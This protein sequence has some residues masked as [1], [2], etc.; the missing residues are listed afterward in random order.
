[1]RRRIM[2][3]VTVCIS[4]MFTTPMPAVRLAAIAAKAAKAFCISE[5][6]RIKIYR[7]PFET[8]AGKMFF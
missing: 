8:A 2:Q 3:F 1:M 7:L 5:K 4:T 6:N